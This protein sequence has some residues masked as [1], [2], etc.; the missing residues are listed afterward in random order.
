MG[1]QQT[2][3]SPCFSLLTTH[4]EDCSLSVHKKAF[5]FFLQL[6]FDSCMDVN[7]E[8]LIANQYNGKLL[9]GFA[10][11]KRSSWHRTDG[12]GSPIIMEHIYYHVY[13]KWNIYLNRYP[14]TLGRILIKI[15]TSV[16]IL[17]HLGCYN[18]ITIDWVAYKQHG[19]ISH[20]SG[21]WTSKVEVP[22]DLVFDEGLFPGSQTALFSPCPHSAEVGREL[23]G[24][25]FRRVLIA[26]M[27]TP[28]SWPNHPSKP[29]PLIPSPW[30]LGFQH[31]NFRGLSACSL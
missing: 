21:G 25:S 6:P 8:L 27:K 28:P 3:F 16:L 22:A 18:K 31:R 19:F 11:T 4:L 12:G 17:V 1:A 29:H 26:F 24:I 20:S 9:Q 30:G 5:L 7:G 13:V 2:W 23:C 10:V 14:C 15:L